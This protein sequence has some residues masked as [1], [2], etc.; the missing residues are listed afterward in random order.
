[1]DN[2]NLKEFA[3]DE[4]M[5]S[6]FTDL[7]AEMD[8]V[9]KEA[10]NNAAQPY[11]QRLLGAIQTVIRINKLPGEW[12]VSKDK[13][14]LIRKNLPPTPEGNISQKNPRKKK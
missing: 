7:E 6:Y 10:A 12:G 4:S 1:M 11:I 5:A 13:K 14:T 2:S 8:R 3:L 9:M